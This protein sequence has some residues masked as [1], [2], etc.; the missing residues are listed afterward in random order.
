MS[1][2]C[3][4]GRDIKTEH[5]G[6][7][8]IFLFSTT[9]FSVPLSVSYCYT[10]V[11]VRSTFP[12]SLL[13]LTSTCRSNVFAIRFYVTQARVEK[14]GR[15]TLSLEVLSGKWREMVTK[16]KNG[17]VSRKSDFDGFSLRLSLLAFYRE[18]EKPSP[19]RYN[20]M[21][22]FFSLDFFFL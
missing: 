12:L 22:V 19:R 1:A 4:T 11:R 8:A 15:I 13:F 14:H 10:C 20:R 9:G 18:T 6:T 16:R 3:T 21:R 17:R 5:V 7:M 2:A